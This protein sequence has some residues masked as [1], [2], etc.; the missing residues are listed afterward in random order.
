MPLRS[1]RAS[2]AEVLVRVRTPRCLRE[3]SGSKPGNPRFHSWAAWFRVEPWAQ[4]P[5]FGTCSR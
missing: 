2:V 5:S 1:D 4:Q 3:D